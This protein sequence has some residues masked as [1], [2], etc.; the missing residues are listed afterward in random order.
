MSLLWC[1]PHAHAAVGD[2]A[3]KR[4]LRLPISRSLEGELAAA[5]A[6]VRSWFATEARAWSCAVE[7]DGE[8]RARLADRLKSGARFAVVAVSAGPEAEAAAAAEWA[9]DR[10]DRWYFLQCYAAAT[11]EQLLADARRRIGAAEHLC[12]GYPGW[13]VE[14]NA[15]LRDA[16][17]R[18]TELPGPLDVLPSGMLRPTK[19]QL[20]I[21]LRPEPAP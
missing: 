2:E 14:D 19:S 11:V 10:P 8:L 18:H 20:A 16:L 9:A 15:W 1:E 12:P 6:W 5:E 3:F 21:C 4:F 13:P 7:A 17:L